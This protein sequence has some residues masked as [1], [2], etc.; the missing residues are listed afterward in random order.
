LPGVRNLTEGYRELFY[1]TPM[2][3]I[4]W[5]E[6]VEDPRDYH[7]ITA[8]VGDTSRRAPGELMSKVLRALKIRGKFAIRIVDGQQGTEVQCA[9]QRKAEADRL[10]GILRATPSSR[11]DAW[12]S[13]RDFVLDAIWLDVFADSVGGEGAY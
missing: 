8:I 11:R 10:A 13:Q 6:I 9:F 5:L 3:E 2:A 12:A 1:V 4:T 7:L